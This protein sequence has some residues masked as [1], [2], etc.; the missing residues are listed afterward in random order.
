[1]TDAASTSTDRDPDV[2]AASDTTPDDRYDV[3]ADAT[4]YDCEYCGRPFAD[5][6]P[7]ALHR[8]LD[9][10]GDLDDDEVEAFRTAYEAEEEALATFRLRALGALVLLY[11][12]LL[13]VYAL[14]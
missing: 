10:P 3:P 7:L 1:M 4:T 5:E 2:P 11:F 14:V 13:M 8:G 12:G 9:H 6:T